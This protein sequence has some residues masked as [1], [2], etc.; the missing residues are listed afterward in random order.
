M[1]RRLGV[2]HRQLF[3]ELILR[4]ILRTLRRIQY[5][6]MA[7]PCRP[8]LVVQLL[9]LA[10]RAELLP[11]AKRLNARQAAASGARIRI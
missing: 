7:R 3:V 6:P 1:G 5:A 4:R 9:D 10:L 2:I 8:A 11:P